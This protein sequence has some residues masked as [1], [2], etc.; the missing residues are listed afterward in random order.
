MEDIAH[1]INPKVD[2]QEHV[3]LVKIIKMR[4]WILNLFQFPFDRRY[5]RNVF[6]NKNANVCLILC[7]EDDR[8]MKC[9][10]NSKLLIC[11]R[12]NC[13]PSLQGLC[14]WHRLNPINNKLWKKTISSAATN[15]LLDKQALYS[16][17]DLIKL[18]LDTTFFRC[19]YKLHENVF[20]HI[21][22]VQE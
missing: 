11:R 22:H 20:V 5:H 19:H 18:L 1:F 4:Y 6:H 10:W 2:W 12:K 17:F 3:E 8:Q 21:K 15:N 9:V 7:K 13:C 14:R 16:C